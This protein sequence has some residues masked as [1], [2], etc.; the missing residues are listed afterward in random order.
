MRT[1]E[2]DRKLEA[3]KGFQSHAGVVIRSIVKDNDSILLPI[4]SLFLKPLVQ[5]AEEDIHDLTV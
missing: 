2:H 4:L 3:L 1:S 5:M